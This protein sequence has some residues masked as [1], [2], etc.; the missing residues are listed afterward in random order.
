[1][2][3]FERRIVAFGA[4]ELEQLAAVANARGKAGERADDLIELLLLL[5]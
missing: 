2:Q 1:L 3:R 5:A 4:R